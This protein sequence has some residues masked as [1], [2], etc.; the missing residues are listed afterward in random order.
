MKAMRPNVLLITVDQMRGDCLG[1]NGHP[2]VETPNLDNL[3][4]KGVRFT[5]AYS[6]T[7]SCIPARAALLTGLTQRTHGRV[8]Y[9]DGVPWNY[10]HY[11]AGEFAAAGYHTQCIGK[12]H[13]YPT[14]SLCGFHNV[15]LH[16]GYLHEVRRHSVSELEGF[17]ACD[18]Y[19]PW[20][21]QRL[22]PEA[23]MIDLGLGCNSWVARPWMYPEH[24]HPTNWTVDRSIDFLR[25]RDPTK[26]FFMMTSFVRPHSPLDPPKAYYDQYINQEF[27]DVPMGDWVDAADTPENHWLT[28]CYDGKLD[29]RALHRARAAYYGL[30]THIDHQIGRLLEALF[31]YE[32]A[33]N[34]I[35][36]FTSDHGDLMG[37]HNMFRKNYPYQ[38]AMNV[39]F[40]L[41]D[42]N[43]LLHLQKGA[44][45]RDLVELRDVMPTLLECAGVPIPDSV[46]GKSVLPLARGEEVEW[47]DYIHG[48]HSRREHSYQ[49]IVTQQYKYI[50]FSDDGREQFFDLESDPTELYNLIEEKSLQEEIDRCRKLLI[51]E[52]TGREEGYTDGKQLIVGRRPLNCLEH[53]R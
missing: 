43:D 45:R 31:E 6:A 34:T 50:W 7:P 51:Q 52:L 11:L 47:R 14:R 21:R 42:P 35:I 2:V 9:E 16:D 36:L 18:D 53:I 12:M 5:N 48:E 24:L 30:I 4:H 17:T 22:G 23:D 37:D 33:Q 40:I 19:L 15:E 38:G 26:P 20:L 28:D 3:A 32:V 49:T 25:R 27:P 13:V 8:G 41:Y 39:P 44:D 29:P 46:E 1:I 10:D